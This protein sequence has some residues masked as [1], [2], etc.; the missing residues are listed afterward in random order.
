MT[1]GDAMSAREREAVARGRSWLGWAAAGPVAYGRGRALAGRL[2]G[3][4]RG[5]K[6]KIGPSSFLFFFFKYL[7]SVIITC[8]KK[9]VLLFVYLFKNCVEFQ[10]S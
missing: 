9:I 10:N 4:D 7:N 8:Q 5:G 1:C 3:P 2:V 6:R